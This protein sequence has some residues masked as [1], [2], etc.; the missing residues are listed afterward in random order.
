MTPTE[1]DPD[2]THI[3]DAMHLI[4]ASLLL[5]GVEA[6]LR[7]MTRVLRD[8]APEFDWEQ[9]LALLARARILGAIAEIEESV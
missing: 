5:H 3:E 1:N 7:A 4:K 8:M 9:K 6:S 2:R